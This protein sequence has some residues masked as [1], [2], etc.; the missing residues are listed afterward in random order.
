MRKECKKCK[1]PFIDAADYKKT[2]IICWKQ[3]K[4]YALNKGDNSYLE[5]Q[6]YAHALEQEIADL[7]KELEE[8]KNEPEP[9]NLSEDQIKALLRL[10]HPDKHSNSKLANE[11]TK[12][13]LAL[14]GK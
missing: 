10:C 6:D 2:C 11:V 9:K 4:G 13:L 1:K 3:E 5:M 14:R 8:D 12:W 7:E